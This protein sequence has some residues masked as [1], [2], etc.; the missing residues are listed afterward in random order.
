[1]STGQRGFGLVE[2]LV[3]LLVLSLGLVAMAALQLK[4]LQGAHEGYQQALA[5]VAA[6]DAQERLWAEYRRAPACADMAIGQVERRWR[7]YWFDEDEALLAGDALGAIERQGCAF[8]IT[9]TRVSFVPATY[10]LELPAR[11][12]ERP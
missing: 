3:A 10:R 8:M 4:S 5:S 7:Q 9:V 11:S 12:A 6:L 1:M 2:S